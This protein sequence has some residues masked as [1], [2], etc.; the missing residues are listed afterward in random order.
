MRRSDPGNNNGQH[1]YPQPRP[2]VKPN[3]TGHLALR[4]ALA[5]HVLS[6][7]QQNGADTWG[8]TS[9]VTLAEDP[10]GL[11]LL[12]RHITVWE[13]KSGEK[14]TVKGSFGGMRR[15]LGAGIVQK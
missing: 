4:S 7:V 3:H 15:V 9:S 1:N 14:E 11:L 8:K 6:H 5:S 2:E 13:G 10:C 12:G